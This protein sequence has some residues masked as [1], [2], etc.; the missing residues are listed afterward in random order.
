MAVIGIIYFYN[1]FRVYI[2]KRSIIV[3]F[4]FGL[5]LVSISA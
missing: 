1:N 2:E 5:A 4:I 3:K